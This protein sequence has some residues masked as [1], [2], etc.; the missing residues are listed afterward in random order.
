MIELLDQQVNSEKSHNLG[1]TN[2]WK[3]YM[4]ARKPSR[5]RHICMHVGGEWPCS[6]ICPMDPLLYVAHDELVRQF[7]V[8][9][10]NFMLVV[11]HHILW[12]DK[13]WHTPKIPLV[14]RGHLLSTC[15]VLA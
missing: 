5:T 4:G 13:R 2:G 6:H 9:G 7:R 14:S 15:V 10:T 11:S 1:R 12:V 3:V 8:V